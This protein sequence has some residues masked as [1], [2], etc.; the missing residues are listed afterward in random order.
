MNN[1]MQE[2][3]NNANVEKICATYV[4]DCVNKLMEHADEM[5]RYWGDK[6]PLMSAE[7]MSELIEAVSGI[8]RGKSSKQDV[9]NEMGDVIIAVSILCARYGIS[10]RDVISRID[11]K[12]KQIF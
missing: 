5:S 6:Y 11:L 2:L 1:T 4:G 10:P 9:I 8:E 7:E 12:I 3:K